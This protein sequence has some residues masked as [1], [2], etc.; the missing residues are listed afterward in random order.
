M[1]DP[2]KLSDFININKKEKKI[3]SAK[4]TEPIK[5]PSHRSKKENISI[6]SELD[7]ESSKEWINSNKL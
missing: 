7:I 3:A 5:H 1:K 4:Y 6:P 2:K